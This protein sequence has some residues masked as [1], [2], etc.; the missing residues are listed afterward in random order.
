MYI[1][2][3]IRIENNIKTVDIVLKTKSKYKAQLAYEGALL[4]I[5]YEL[6]QQQYKEYPDEY[7]TKIKYNNK[8]VL[9]TIDKERRTEHER[10]NKY[11]TRY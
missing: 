7:R 10:R 11:A 8:L 2:K 3:I 5:H 6:H 9:I 1:V 4:G